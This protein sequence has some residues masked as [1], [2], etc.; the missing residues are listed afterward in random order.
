M[1]EN[2]A[3]GAVS[4]LH[5]FSSLSVLFRRRNL[6][7]WR[8]TIPLR[9]VGSLSSLVQAVSREECSWVTR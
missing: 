3:D 4:S 6:I 5:L 2:A 7:V 9:P 1:Q 8:L